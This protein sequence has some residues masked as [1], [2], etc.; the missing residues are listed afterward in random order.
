MDARTV[1]PEMMLL[2]A[3]EDVRSGERTEGKM[4]IMFID[5]GDPFKMHYY[6]SGMRVDECASICDFGNALFKKE[7]GL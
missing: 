4:L 3:L 7:L 2:T 5:P 6:N 1:T